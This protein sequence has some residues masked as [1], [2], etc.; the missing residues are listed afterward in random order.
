MPMA[1]IAVSIDQKV[2]RRLDGLV[3]KG[4]FPSRSKAI[5]E[6]IE[7]QLQKLDRSRLA[8]ECAKLDPKLEQQVAEEGM[9]Y[10][11]GS[12]PEY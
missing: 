12:W 2:V 9:S 3:L 4:F 5:Q 6:A 1:K 8:I 10:E 7:N 11:A